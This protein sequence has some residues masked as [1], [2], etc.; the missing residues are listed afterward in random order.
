MCETIS[1]RSLD[2]RGTLNFMTARFIEP[3]KLA[4]RVNTQISENFDV[5]LSLNITGAS[6]R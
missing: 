1:K 4:A 2:L 3:V 6:E 5:P